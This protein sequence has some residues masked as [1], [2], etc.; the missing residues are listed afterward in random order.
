MAKIR[1]LV[2][3]DII[4]DFLKGLRAAKDIFRSDRLE[5]Y[6]SVLSKKELISKVGLK[7]SERRKIL[8]LLSKIKVLKIDSDISKKFSLLMRKYGEKPDAIVDYVIAAT[9]WSKNLPLLTRNRKHFEHIREITLTP[10]YDY[11]EQRR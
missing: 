8:E 5:I 9:A 2:D 11:E 3:T 10:I 4:I 6:C 1:L 7:D